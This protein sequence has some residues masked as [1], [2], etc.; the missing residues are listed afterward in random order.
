MRALPGATIDVSVM[1]R[2]LERA[3]F[4]VFQEVDCEKGRYMRAACDESV[5]SISTRM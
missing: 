2:N 1:R 3:G 5:L 4:E